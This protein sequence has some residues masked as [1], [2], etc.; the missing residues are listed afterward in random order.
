MMSSLS[1]SDIGEKKMRLSPGRLLIVVLLSCLLFACAKKPSPTPKV[2]GT[3]TP[4]PEW[5]KSWTYSADKICGIGM[6]GPGFPGSPYPEEQARNRAITNLAGS[7]ETAVQEAIIATQKESGSRVT[8]RRHFEIDQALL[9]DVNARAKLDYWVDAHGEGP[10]AGPGFTYSRACLDAATGLTDPALDK[11]V[12]RALATGQQGAMKEVPAWLNYQGTQPGGRLCAVGFS[13]PAFY[14]EQTFGNVV[15]NVRGQLAQIITTLVSEY[16]HDAQGSVQLNEIMTVASS[17]GVAE[18]V[19]VTHYWFDA[20]GE[21]PMSQKEATYGWGCVYP[22]RILQSAVE[23]AQSILPQEEQAVL[24][25]VRIR[26]DSAF[27]DLQ[28]VESNQPR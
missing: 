23:S 14:A 9:D 15:E 26:A 1:V 28:E 5:I 25:A 6:A 19:V 13:Q 24:E 18:G 2:V 3:P 16:Q 7:I 10:F 22:N 27:K 8:M 4:V 21:G 20:H 12:E 11:L 17:K